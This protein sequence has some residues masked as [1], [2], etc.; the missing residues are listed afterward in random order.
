M[1]K[2]VRA[3]IY[4]LVQGVGLRYQVQKKASQLGLT[5]FVKNLPDGSVELVAEGEEDLINELIEYVKTGIRWARV[6]KVELEWSEWEG[7]Y[8]RF[9]I[10][11]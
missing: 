2:K 9:E 5:G 4:G 11:F 3:L 1:K 7:K 6:E 10:A 8:R